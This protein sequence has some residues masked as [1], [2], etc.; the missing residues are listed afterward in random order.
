[1]TPSPQP[2]HMAYLGGAT[3]SCPS[4]TQ[5]LPTD[6]SP[7]PR[8]SQ[9][10]EQVCSESPGELPTS[11][12]ATSTK[13]RTGLL[14]PQSETKTLPVLPE[15]QGQ[16]PG[17]CECF[18]A[19]LTLLEDFEN[20][21]STVNTQ[22]ID[23]ILS[24][25]KKALSHCTHVIRCPACVARSD[26]MVLLGVLSDK[27][28]TLYEQIIARNMEDLLH[29]CSNDQIYYGN[30]NNG[31]GRRSGTCTP[32]PPTF[33]RE[34]AALVTGSL[35]L[36]CYRIEGQKERDCVVRVLIALQLRQ[37]F[38]LLGHM[39][40]IAERMWREPHVSALRVRKQRLKVITERV[41]KFS[42]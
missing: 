37:V 15:T 36:G 3:A 31:E 23:S 38:S 7:P 4:T 19:T 9:A 5:Q 18:Q 20:V 17:D 32:F 14:N 8:K 25:Q 28:I 1:M 6:T 24:Y 41:R 27:L 10:K 22:S 35:S 29:R 40:V 12:S 16:K 33:Q 21:A 42:G 39:Q 26:S 30:R 13:Q 2:V 11:P 34:Q